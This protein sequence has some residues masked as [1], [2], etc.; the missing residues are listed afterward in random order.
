[1]FYNEVELQTNMKLVERDGQEVEQWVKEEVSNIIREGT[2]GNIF[3]LV[4]TY[5][6]FLFLKWYSSYDDELS[7]CPVELRNLSD[8]QYLV[9]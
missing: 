4:G 7:V 2:K 1:M 9:P 8:I 3:E 6:D 5:G